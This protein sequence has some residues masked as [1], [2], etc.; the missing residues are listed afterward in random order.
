MTANDLRMIALIKM[1]L[2]AHE[3]ASLLNISPEGVKK[4]RYRLKRKM[5]LTAEESLNDTILALKQTSWTI[6]DLRHVIPW[7]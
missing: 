4:A 5:E 7:L 2:S 1:N 3:I 6:P